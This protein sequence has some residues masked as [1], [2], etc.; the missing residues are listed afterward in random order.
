[1]QASLDISEWIMTYSAFKSTT[2]AFNL[3]VRNMTYLEW[4]DHSALK[5]LFFFEETTFDINK[6]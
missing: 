3:G 1:M 4:G 5:L 2:C 6:L